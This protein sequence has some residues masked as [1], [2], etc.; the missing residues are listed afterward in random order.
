M[1]ELNKFLIIFVVVKRQ[2]WYSIGKLETKRV[3]SIVHEYYVFD[4][5][6]SDHSQILDVDALG[7]AYAVMSIEAR[8]F[9]LWVDKLIEDRVS[10]CLMTRGKYSHFKAQF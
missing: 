10:I 5:S 2:N 9:S 7:R 3:N 1:Q 8:I 6:I 4:I